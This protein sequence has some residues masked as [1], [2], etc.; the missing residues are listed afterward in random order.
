MHNFAF[1]PARS[2]SKGLINKN[3]KEINGKPLLAYS[4]LAARESGKFDVIHVS[5]DSEEYAEIA[6]K[7]GADVPFLRPSK[8]AGDTSTTRDAT[9][10]S[11]NEYKKMGY[12]FD[13]ITTLQ[14]TS[15]LRTSEDIMGAFGLF[16]S[17]K[18]NAVISVCEAEHPPMWSNVLTED[19]NMIHFLE[20]DNEDRRQDLPQYYRLNGAIYLS[21]LDY[22][23]KESSLYNDKCYAYIMPKERSVDID[24]A[25]DFF[26]A[27]SIMKGMT[28]GR[29]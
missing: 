27:E 11:V 9:L 28:E 10:Y 15:P 12:C 16:E 3:I 18:A 1:I 7:W 13:T 6:K 26:M 25:F 20:T 19:G 22:Y 24:D 14:P 17:K 8:L 4:I 21:K 5:T 23:I 2:G 29:I